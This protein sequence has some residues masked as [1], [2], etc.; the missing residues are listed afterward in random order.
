MKTLLW[1]FS[2]WM[3]EIVHVDGLVDDP[4]DPKDQ[5]MMKLTR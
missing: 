4:L 2:T 3:V 1:K 5:G